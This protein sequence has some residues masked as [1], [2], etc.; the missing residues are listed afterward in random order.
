M[1]VVDRIPELT[2]SRPPRNAYDYVIVG[3]GTAGRVLAASLSEHPDT[4]V[5]LLEA[6]PW[7]LAA[8]G[9][10]ETEPEPALGRR[11]VSW[12][13]RGDNMQIPPAPDAVASWYVPGWSPAELGTGVET[14]PA[15]AHDPLTHSL[16]DCACQFG[17]KINPG[18]ANGA[19]GVSAHPV[20]MPQSSP[21]RLLSP[22]RPNLTI[23]ANAFVTRILLNGLRATGVF[24][25]ERHH[26]E[27]AIEALREVIVCAGAARTPQLLML[28]GIGPAGRLQ[29]AGIDVVAELPGVGESLADPLE[30]PLT[31][32]SLEAQPGRLAALFHHGH[33]QRGRT[34]TGFLSANPGSGLND[35][36]IAFEPRTAGRTFTIHVAY[37]FPLSRGF[38]SLR[39]RDP[40]LPP[41]IRA[42]YLWDDDDL[43]NLVAAVSLVRD[44]VGQ[45]AFEP[46]RGGELFPGPEAHT[47][48]QLAI[49]VRRGAISAR[50]AT[51]TCRMGTDAL[52]V[53]DPLLRVRGV[54]GLRI[55]GGCV[56]PGSPGAI[57]AAPTAALA[58]RAAD[59]ITGRAHIEPVAATARG[60]STP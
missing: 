49:A 24:V 18:F 55:A 33:H 47:A 56:M 12:W 38:V 15:T 48:A 5:L 8:A 32:E 3:G 25:R 42:N 2:R 9:A 34:A 28:S 6:S 60:P 51:G 39:G 58:L 10:L 11:R 27:A 16:I 59:L 50:A 45:V 53:V 4:T 13:Q 54:E 1:T 44:V 52:A 26:P 29:A 22:H 31:F 23:R 20:G 46:Y 14:A 43:D 21:A 41:L 57:S 7:R 30:L 40:A 37:L 36:Q 17:L 35:L 19:T